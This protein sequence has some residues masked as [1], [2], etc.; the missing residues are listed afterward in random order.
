MQESNRAK[1]KWYMYFL[2]SFKITYELHFVTNLREQF[3]LDLCYMHLI[4]N[5][6]ATKQDFFYFS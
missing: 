5:F 4:H 2:F 1:V 3:G 6:G